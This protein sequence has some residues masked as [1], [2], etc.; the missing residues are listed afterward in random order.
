M[1]S[2]RMAILW[3]IGILS[4][5]AL[6]CAEGFPGTASVAPVIGEIGADLA[7]EQGTRHEIEFLSL[8]RFA[9]HEMN[10]LRER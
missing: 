6:S 4:I 2:R 5:R 7:L 1:R 9:Q 8:Q 3:S 10:R